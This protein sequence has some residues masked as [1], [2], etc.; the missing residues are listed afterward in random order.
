MVQER[1]LLS[2]SPH[3]HN[4]VPGCPLVQILPLDSRRHHVR[5][6][7]RRAG[8]TG[9][10]KP[11]QRR[12]IVLFEAWGAV[13][14]EREQTHRLHAA[15]H[16]FRRPAQHLLRVPTFVQIG[17]EYQDGLRGTGN[18]LLAVRQGAIDVGTTAKLCAEEQ[19]N[20]ILQVIGEVNNRCV[21]DNHARADGANRCQHRSENARVDH[22]GRHRTALIHA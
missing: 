18:D 4:I 15:A 19:V 13:V 5:K 2:F 8:E 14:T 3:R 16:Q 11:C 10:A 20:G 22:G 17:N 12:R 1:R 7:V 6:Q 9:K 21:E